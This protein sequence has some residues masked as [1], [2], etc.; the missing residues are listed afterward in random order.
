MKIKNLIDDGLVAVLK[1]Y[2]DGGTNKYGKTK[3]SKGVKKGGGDWHCLG[4]R[5][6]KSCDY[7]FCAPIGIRTM[8]YDSV[9]NAPTTHKNGAKL[10]MGSEL[11]NNSAEVA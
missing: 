2:V 1:F 3:W 8:N 6:K 5:N 11:T 4:A 9:Y 10:F 7:S